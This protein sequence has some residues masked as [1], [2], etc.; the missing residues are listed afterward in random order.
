MKLYNVTA[1]YARTVNGW[2]RTGQV[3]SFLVSDYSAQSAEDAARIGEGI[4]QAGLTP[5]DD[6]TF[7]VTAVEIG[8]YK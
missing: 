4:L 7:Y 6:V 2:E 8:E 1:T 5:E 3:H